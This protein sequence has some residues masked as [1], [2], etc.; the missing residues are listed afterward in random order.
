MVDVV[1]AFTTSLTVETPFTSEQQNSR[2]DQRRCAASTM[3]T[4]SLLVLV[5][6]VSLLLSFCGGSSLTDAKA[7]SGSVRGQ[8]KERRKRQA[9]KHFAVPF[10]AVFCEGSANSV[11]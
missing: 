4:K 10:L 6:T 3:A 1:N 5:V 2:G 8:I 7:E 9:T 11:I